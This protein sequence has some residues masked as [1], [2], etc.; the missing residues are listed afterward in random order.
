MSDN[1]KEKKTEQGSYIIRKSTYVE[2]IKEAT[3]TK[4]SANFVL[5]KILREYFNLD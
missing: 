4:R 3:K 5:E 2:L 1:K